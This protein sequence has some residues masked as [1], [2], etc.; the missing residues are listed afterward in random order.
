MS[1][2]PDVL[3]AHIHPEHVASIRVAEACGLVRTGLVDDEGEGIWR[4]TRPAV[5]PA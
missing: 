4:W 1:D 3:D 5:S 2:A